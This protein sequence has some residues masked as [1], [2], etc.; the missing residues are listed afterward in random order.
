MATFGRHFELWLLS[1]GISVVKCATTLKCGCV[2]QPTSGLSKRLV[3]VVL[4]W[5]VNVV[6]H[7]TCVIDDGIARQ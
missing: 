6:A 7:F 4:P 2:R 1:V 3:E 5:R